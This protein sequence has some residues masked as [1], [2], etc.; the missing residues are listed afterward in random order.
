LA[1]QQAP[2]LAVLKGGGGGRVRRPHAN[3]VC[4]LGKVSCTTSANSPS[5]L[6]TGSSTAHK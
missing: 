4:N 5:R 3:A 1:R 6:R 2:R